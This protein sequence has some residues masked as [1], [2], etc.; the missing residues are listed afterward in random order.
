MGRRL[1]EPMSSRLF[2]SIIV[3]PLFCTACAGMIAG[4]KGWFDGQK[5]DVEPKAKSDLGCSDKPLEFSPVT[6]DDYREVEARG[7]GKKARYKF[8]KVGP[9]GNW[10]K[11]EG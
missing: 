6:M 4:S 5:S 10:V 9:V 2:S 8:V 1:E 11:S 3:V 7:C